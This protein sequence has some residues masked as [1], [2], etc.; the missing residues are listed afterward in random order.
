MQDALLIQVFLTVPRI[1]TCY[2]FYYLGSLTFD[3]IEWVVHSQFL[4]QKCSHWAH[5]I[6]GWLYLTNRIRFI[7]LFSLLTIK[8]QFHTS[9]LSFTGFNHL[10]IGH[11]WPILPLMFWPSSSSEWL[12]GTISHWWPCSLLTGSVHSTER[13]LGNYLTF[14]T[15]VD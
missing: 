2:R 9:S 15:P 12:P 4:P 11:Q 14:L 5:P 10:G 8:C 7:A 6:E 3:T 1:S 13:F